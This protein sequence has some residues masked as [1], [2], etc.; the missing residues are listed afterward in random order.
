MRTG[1]QIDRR[2]SPL[3]V[4]TGIPLFRPDPT[5]WPWPPQFSADRAGLLVSRP[6]RACD[7]TLALAPVSETL[8]LSAYTPSAVETIPTLL[9]HPV[10]AE[11]A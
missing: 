3:Y 11:M 1:F 8:A 9:L 2:Q 5:K 4:E 10:L 6:A 7:Q